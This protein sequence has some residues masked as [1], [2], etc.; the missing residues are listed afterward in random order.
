[1]TLQWNGLKESP[2]T[3]KVYLACYVK[4][5]Y[6][7]GLQTGQSLYWQDVEAHLVTPH[8]TALDMLAGYYIGD[9]LL[10]IGVVE[11]VGMHG[12]FIQTSGFLGENSAA[13]A[14]AVK[15]FACNPYDGEAGMEESLDG[16]W[17]RY[18]DVERLIQ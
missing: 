10:G 8:G 3:A 6:F 1:V 2:G 12:V 13:T 14:R 18:A 9:R 17:V 15:R 11:K 16:E 5:Q 7:G 4:E